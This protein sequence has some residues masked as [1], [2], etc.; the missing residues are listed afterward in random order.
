MSPLTP[1]V[2]WGDAEKAAWRAHVGAP[3]RSYAEE[4]LAKLEPLKAGPSGFF[5]SQPPSS[6]PSTIIPTSDTC[7]PVHPRS[8]STLV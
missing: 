3:Q 2:A 8:P 6:E 4:V 7:T 5:A 1:G